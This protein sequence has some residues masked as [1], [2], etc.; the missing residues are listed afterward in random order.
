MVT[1]VRHTDQAP[2]TRFS[3][4][5]GRFSRASTNPHSTDEDE[6]RRKAT[7]LQSIDGSPELGQDVRAASQQEEPGSRT[8]APPL[9]LK[10][11]SLCSLSLAPPGLA[12]P[13]CSIFPA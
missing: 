4:G 2:T 1:S 10:S 7:T 11:S 13:P 12:V 6:E 5:F 3:Q 9:L 8:M